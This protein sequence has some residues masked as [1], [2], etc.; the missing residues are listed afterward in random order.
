VKLVL[1]G[2]K[3]WR[4][5]LGDLAGKERNQFPFFI[6][7]GREDTT[8]VTPDCWQ[9]WLSATADEIDRRS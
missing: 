9:G 4:E 3:A 8:P 2:L 7:R 5:A 6:V 1:E